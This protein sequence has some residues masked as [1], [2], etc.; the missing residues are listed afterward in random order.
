MSEVLQPIPDERSAPF[1]DG[2]REGRLMLQRCTSCGVWHYPVRTRCPAC[3]QAS[4][5]WAAASGRGVVF[6]HGRPHRVPA[7]LEARMPLTLVVVDLQEGVR[8]SSNLI[9][10]DPARV[11][12]GMRVE[13]AFEKLSGESVLP[14][15]RPSAS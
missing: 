11:R 6:S 12:T 15:F 3:Q 10:A 13:V 4:L 5:E 2:A 1:F 14:V 9:D 8:M 7:G